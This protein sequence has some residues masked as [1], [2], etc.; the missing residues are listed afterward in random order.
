VV[1]A[2]ADMAALAQKML[3]MLMMINLLVRVMFDM[4]VTP[5]S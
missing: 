4:I 1:S 5:L 3:A 2:L